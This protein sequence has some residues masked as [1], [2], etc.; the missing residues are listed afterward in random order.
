MVSY[1]LPFFGEN[2]PKETRLVYR[3]GI[4]TGRKLIWLFCS[5]LLGLLFSVFPE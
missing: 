1:F 5:G 3:N 4:V 2:R